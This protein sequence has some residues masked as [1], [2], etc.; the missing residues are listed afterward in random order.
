MLA[1]GLKACDPERLVLLGA[2]GGRIELEAFDGLLRGD[3]V[4]LGIGNHR[5]DGGLAK[6]AIVGGRQQRIVIRE[7][8]VGGVEVLEGGHP[9]LGVM[10]GWR[11]EDGGWMMKEDEGG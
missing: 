5:V 6:P 8:Q 2:R 3:A 4:L 10:A 11:T 1:E 7:L 9:R